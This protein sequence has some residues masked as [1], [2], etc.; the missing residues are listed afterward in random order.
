MSSLDTK[1]SNNKSMQ[2]KAK[3][4][5]SRRHKIPSSSQHTIHPKKISNQ[6]TSLDQYFKDEYARSLADT[7]NHSCRHYIIT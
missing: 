5:A 7:Q 4:K 3:T 6:P 2:K 1:Q